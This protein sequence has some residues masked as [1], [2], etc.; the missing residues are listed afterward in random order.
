MIRNAV[1]FRLLCLLA[2]FA[3]LV[4]TGCGSTPEDDTGL[5][6]PT[7]PLGNWTAAATGNFS[8]L[9]AVGEG[10]FTL[11][12]QDPARPRL[13]MSTT[14][15]SFSATGSQTN[16]AARESVEYRFTG[17]FNTFSINGNLT[18]VRRRSPGGT[19]FSTETIRII[20]V[21]QRHETAALR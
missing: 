17:T 11:D 3:V 6:K 20:A 9:P 16:A 19:I 18:I 21:K 14:G 1:L 8:V 15:L 5:A 10:A 2:V 13:A 4:L 12:F 7:K